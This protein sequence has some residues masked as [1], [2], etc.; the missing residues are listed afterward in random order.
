M[1]ETR[2]RMSFDPE[3]QAES[4]V[5]PSHQLP[6]IAVHCFTGKLD[7]A[8]AYLDS[9]C[10]IGLTG[11]ICKP[12]RGEAL[13]NII[14]PSVPLERIMIETDASFKSFTKGQRDSEPAHVVRVAMQ[15]SQTHGIPLERVCSVTNGT[16][17]KFFRLE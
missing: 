12:D 10:Y 6:P 7:E 15:V 13:R 9:G 11:F 1:N 3:I 17:T 14:L 16:A 5:C 8:L 4:S 2:T